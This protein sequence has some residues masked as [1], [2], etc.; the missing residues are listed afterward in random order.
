VLIRLG[1]IGSD[2]AMLL[3]FIGYRREAA[4]FETLILSNI[5]KHKWRCK[6]PSRTISY[7]I[8]SVSQ[9]VVLV[10]SCQISDAP[11]F[12]IAKIGYLH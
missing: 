8:P 10:H 6:A 5:Y 9:A 4:S 2:Q 7:F 3:R 1:L 12:A 11:I